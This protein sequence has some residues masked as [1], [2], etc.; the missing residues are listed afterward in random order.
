LNSVPFES[1]WLPGVH[2][3]RTPTSI[4]SIGYKQESPQE[5]ASN[6]PL[7]AEKAGVVNK[8]QHIIHKAVA[9]KKMFDDGEVRSLSEIA[10]KEGLTRARVTQIMNLLKLI[11]DWKNFLLGLTDPKEI[12]RYSERRLRNYYSGGYT[13][14]PIKKKS[15]PELIAEIPKKSRGKQKQPS[16]IIVVEIDEPLSVMNLEAQKEL[17][18]KAALR[19]LK[20]L[21]GK[22]S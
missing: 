2:D 12:R 5:P 15:C 17:I 11:P 13:P 19:K 20:K 10:Q 3:L 1:E 6:E 14:P 9:W 16:K 21:E 8:P 7:E 4:D 22:N 18:K